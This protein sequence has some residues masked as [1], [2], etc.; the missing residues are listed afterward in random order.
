MK[1]V[2]SDQPV[3]NSVS[4]RRHDFMPPGIR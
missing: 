4:R 2:C 3:K 1:S